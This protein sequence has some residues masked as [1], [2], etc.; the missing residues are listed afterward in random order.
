MWLGEYR[1]H[2]RIM[3]PAALQGAFAIAAAAEVFNTREILVEAMRLHKPIVF[4]DEASAGGAG[5]W[6]RTVQVVVAPT[7]QVESRVVRVFSSGGRDQ[8]W[9]LHSES[10]V[11]PCPASLG[12]ATKS[13]IETLRSDLSPVDLSAFHAAPAK[14]GIECGPAFRR[15]RAVWSGGGVAF[16]EITLPEESASGPGHLHA[17]L[18]EAC[19]QVL[20]AAP[21]VADG[22][23]L[24]VHLPVGWDRLQ[25]TSPIPQS[26]VCFATVRAT[27]SERGSAAGTDP[28]L[29]GGY[30]ADEP[31]AD[32]LLA[33]VVLYDADGVRLGQ[34]S[35]LAV[36]RATRAALLSSVGERRTAVFLVSPESIASGVEDGRIHLI[37]EGVST[38]QLSALRADLER[39]SRSYALAGLERLGWQPEAGSVLTLSELRKDL[40]IVP[41]HE[42]LLRRMVGMLVEDGLLAPVPDKSA[43]TVVPGADRTSVE[44]SRD[45]PDGLA[46]SLADRHPYGSSEIRLLARCGGALDEVLRGKTD[47]Q[48]L[49]LG[50]DHP[51]AGDLYREAPVVRAASKGL[52]Q[53]LAAITADLPANGRLRV[54]EVGAGTGTITEFALS[55]LP[56]GRYDYVFT[57]A[58][59]AFL[60]DAEARFGVD[61]RSIDYRVLDIEKDPSSQGFEEHTY[62]LVIA[63]HAVHANRDLK[64][65]FEHCLRL[66]APSGQLVALEW[67]QGSGWLDLTFGL[68]GGSWR[69]S[70]AYRSDSAAAA[71]T[72]L[73]Q[74]LADAGFREITVLNAR[75]AQ[76][77]AT[78]ALGIVAARAPAHSAE[79]RGTWVPAA[80]STGRPAALAA[81]PAEIISP[82]APAAADT[83]PAGLDLPE[84]LRQAHDSA[85]GGAARLGPAGGTPE[86][87][88]EADPPRADSRVLRPRPRLNHGQGAGRSAQPHAVRGKRGVGNRSVRALQHGR[89]GP[90]R[91]SRPR[92]AR[93]L[94][95]QSRATGDSA[96]YG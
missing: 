78:A 80:D 10:R 14:V 4:P 2:G 49:L 94:T 44:G 15:V 74:A 54:L 30:V 76:P 67:L 16:G 38:G 66:M 18:L 53:A 39:L 57:D 23:D 92:D 86:L 61:D 55:E 79:P 73:R 9:L 13:D 17:A 19:L 33:D 22:D 8:P 50:S 40:D 26:V 82:A 35:G 85:R 63:G 60:S 41:Q 88:E 28:A 6:S 84:Q 95:R 96:G 42:G 31:P 12:V 34:L 21:Q 27:D 5:A 46:A 45:D 91:G 7:D 70:D 36:R 72:A 37:S 3:A 25:L 48:E 64:A 89:L 43:W 69:F 75:D 1:I 52:G 71:Q 65:T 47:P 58:S 83:G 93:S 56:A 24:A 32:C 87:A 81:S 68:L 11:S 90:S 20:M 51:N 29:A 59:K 62:D 77:E